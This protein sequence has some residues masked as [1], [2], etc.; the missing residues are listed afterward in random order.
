MISIISQSD[1]IGRIRELKENLLYLSSLPE[2]S[3]VNIHKIDFVTPLSII[4]IASIINKKKLICN[5]KRE[6][7]SY[8]HVI[9]FLQGTKELLNQG[10]RKTYIPIIHLQLCNLSK[11]EISRFLNELHSKFLNLLRINI[12]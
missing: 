8:L 9:H 2:G 6:N 4:P 12:I 11:Q 1:T 5:Y 7:A 10:L 3:I